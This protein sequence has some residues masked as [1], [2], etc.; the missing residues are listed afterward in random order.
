MKKI[1]YNFHNCWK[2]QELSSF[3][4]RGFHFAYDIYDDGG[5]YINIVL[6]NFEF[7]I[8]IEKK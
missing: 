3:W 8:Y 5:V 1:V 7:S 4:F 6:F 2:C